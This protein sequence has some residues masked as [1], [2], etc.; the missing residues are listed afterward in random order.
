MAIFYFYSY[1]KEI[2]LTQG[3]FALVDDV[4]FEWLSRWKWCA[5]K[6][7]SNGYY[8]GRTVQ[9]KKPNG[10]YSTKTILMHRVILGL[11]D[12]KTHTDHINHNTLDN[13]KINLR[14][15]TPA[16][17]QRNSTSQKNSSSKYL[18]VGWNKA[19]KKWRSQ[20]IIAGKYK[21][22]GSFTCEIKAALAYNEAAL[23]YFG[24]FANL[25]II[26]ESNL[27]TYQKSAV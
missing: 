21:Y 9:F 25:N 10:R 17:N 4:D 14:E 22:L 15:C 23:E 26:P 12:G 24:E 6:H 2:P 13:Q 8:A 16:E 27:L 11:T 7:T 3:Q 5:M 18:G 19:A 1:M 20:L